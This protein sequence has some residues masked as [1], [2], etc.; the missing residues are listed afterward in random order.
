M[1][2]KPTPTITIETQPRSWHLAEVEVDGTLA[3]YVACPYGATVWNSYG[4]DNFGSYALAADLENPGSCAVHPTRD[5]AAEHVAR[6][7][8]I[9]SAAA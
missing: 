7:Y 1:T 8:A 6:A 5:E 4:V 2:S 3:G 9:R